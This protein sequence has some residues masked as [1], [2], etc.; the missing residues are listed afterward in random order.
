MKNEALEWMTTYKDASFN[1]M[2]ALIGD[3]VRAKFSPSKPQ[4]DFPAFDSGNLPQY[5]VSE[6][7]PGY[8]IMQKGPEYFRVDYTI[9]ADGAPVVGDEIIPVEK[10]WIPKPKKVADNALGSQ[11]L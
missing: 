2:N 6:V 7:Y 1:D 9:G 3:A 10:A 4:Y 8:V 5:W 11:A